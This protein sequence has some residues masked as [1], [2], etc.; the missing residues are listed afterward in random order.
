MHNICLQTLKENNTFYYTISGLKRK[1]NK[2]ITFI[3]RNEQ[4]SK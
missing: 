3:F 1:K 4:N 2:C